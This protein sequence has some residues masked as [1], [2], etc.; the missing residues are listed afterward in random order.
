M[1]YEYCA[2][3]IRNELC[4]AYAGAARLTAGLKER[5]GGADGC[6]RD[7]AHENISSGPAREPELDFWLPMIFVQMTKPV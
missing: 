1:H 6:S 5:I 3:I 7:T 2:G 4:S